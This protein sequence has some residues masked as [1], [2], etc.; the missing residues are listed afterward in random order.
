MAQRQGKDNTLHQAVI[1]CMMSFFAANYQMV[2]AVKYE[3]LHCYFQR[4]HTLAEIGELN[5]ISRERVRKII[6]ATLKRFNDDALTL[7]LMAVRNELSEIRHKA[8]LYDEIVKAEEATK[9]QEEA[10]RQAIAALE[11][12]VESLQL[13]ARARNVLTKSRIYTITQLCD[14]TEH[15]LGCIRS[16]GKGT[17]IEIKAEIA[18]LGLSLRD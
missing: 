9:K 17:V 1:K 6:A 3:M 4:G 14:L 13:S 2:G 8:K 5:G 7:D 10:R 16:C 18:R 11:G 15:E 12:T